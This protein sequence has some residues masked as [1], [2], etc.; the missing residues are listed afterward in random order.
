MHTWGVPLVP[1]VLLMITNYDI[2]MRLLSVPR[3]NGSQAEQAT[4]RALRDWLQARGIAHRMQPFRLYPYFNEAVGLWLIVSRTL[5]AA[6]VIGQWG[7]WTLPIALIG[8]LGGLL[9]VT[10]GVPLA[11]WPG[12]RQGANLLVELTP[13][14]PR[15]EIILAAHYDSKT[16]LLDHQRRAFFTRNLAL[17]IGLT[18]LLGL[19]GPLAAWLFPASA[20]GQAVVYWLSVLLT[21]P[22]LVLAWGLGLNLALGRLSEPSQGAVDNGVACAI[23]L[24][25]AE[26]LANGPWQPEQTRVVLALFGGEE[27]SMQ[28][29]RAY[30]RERDWPQP[31]VVL[32]LELMGQDGDY[33]L[34]QR[35]GNALRRLPTTA[36][37]NTALAQV[38]AAVTGR[39]PRA[40]EQINSD[41]FS[42]LA[43]GVPTA[44]L[45]TYHSRMGA[46]GLHRPSDNRDRV[47]LRRLPE[48]VEIL[49][50]FMQQYDQGLLLEDA[51]SSAGGRMSRKTSATSSGISSSAKKTI[52]IGAKRK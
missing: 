42:F 19:W 39:P 1:G 5:L 27:V 40:V 20:L 10:L 2:L 44:V 14:Q 48:A 15:R 3:P 28:G 46:G 37:L 43:A 38:V 24:G 25:L 26:R 36:W 12:A 52:Q 32:N 22:V 11:S 21:L 35:D 47:V 34:W 50:R 17:G 41:G 51:A 13:A 45:G 16:E 8:L 29:S 9:D 18:L 6:A 31:A 4:L 49:L 23:L 30:V 33:V 7:W